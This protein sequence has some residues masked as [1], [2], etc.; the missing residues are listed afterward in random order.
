MIAFSESQLL[1]WVSAW[2]LPFFRIL[3][4]MSSAPVLSSRSI[5]LR[6]KLGLAA[7]LAVTVAPFAPLPLDFSIASPMAIAAIL[8]ELMIGLALGFL[9]RLV[10][11]VFELCGEMVGLQMGLSYAGYF[12]P[13]AGQ[14]NAVASFTGIL[15]SWLFVI[16]NGPVLLLGCLIH[17]YERFPVGSAL[18]DIKMLNTGVMVGFLSDIFSMALLLALPV[19][20]V[21]LLVNFAMGVATKIAPQLN[22][23]AVGFPVLLLCGMGM[24]GLV[25][26]HFEE[27]LTKSLTMVFS[28]W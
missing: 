20:A 14:G 10:L 9:T 7:I 27:T 18:P 17:S 1:L 4:V 3:A 19:L 11:L 25:M 13:N 5:A 12:S 24:L 21:L 26:P 15:G 28:L 23:F 6:T 22:L 2:L 8:R 16:V